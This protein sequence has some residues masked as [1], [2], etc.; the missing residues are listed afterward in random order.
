MILTERDRLRLAGVNTDL[1]RVIEHAAAITDQPFTVLE[2]VRT[3]E[4]Q[5]ALKASGASL[6]LDSRHLTG[7]AVDIAPLDD[8]AK[9]S[10]HW[11]LYHRLAKIIK[12]AA[13]E[14][15][16]T[17]EW[18][19]DWKRFKDGPHWQLPKTLYP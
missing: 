15:G 5:R 6:T 11:P 18:G 8:S 17:V 7:H 12:R 10:W 1:I 4:R 14:Q 19:G 16:V 9:V 2:G 13:V 3:L